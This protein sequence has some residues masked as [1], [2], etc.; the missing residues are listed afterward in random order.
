MSQGTI[1]LT[2]S[3]SSEDC[4][5]N[6][7]GAIIEIEKNTT[8]RYIDE[9]VGC[10]ICY[11]RL[12]WNDGISN[13]IQIKRSQAEMVLWQHSGQIII[14]GNVASIELVNVMGQVV[15]ANQSNRL[16][17]GDLPNGVYLVKALINGEYVIKKIVL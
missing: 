1:N 16:Y 15:S 3:A 14:D 7:E 2:I 13:V 6:N 9:G 8:Y 4:G 10:D 17:V 12:S 11:Y 5:E